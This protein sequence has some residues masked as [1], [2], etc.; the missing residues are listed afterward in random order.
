MT[1]VDP[2]AILAIGLMT[3]GIS[4]FALVTAGIA[5]WFVQ[6]E[7]GRADPDIAALRADVAEMKRTLQILADRKMGR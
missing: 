5:S 6:D 4:T 1:T 7:R 3:V 2:T